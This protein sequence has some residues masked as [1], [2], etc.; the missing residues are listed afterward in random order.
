[1]PVD[2]RAIESEILAGFSNEKNRLKDAY[3]NRRFYEG[4]FD[5][6]PTRIEGA[7]Y[8]RFDFRRTSRIM[9]RIVDTLCGHLYKKPPARKIPGDKRGTDSLASIYRRNQMAAMWLFA[10]RMTCVGDFA[11]WQFAGGTDP[12]APVKIHLRDADQTIVWTDGSDATKAGAVGIIEMANG[13]RVLRLWTPDEVRTYQTDQREVSLP[14]QQSGGTAYRLINRALNPY[15]DTD[16]AGILPFSF[17]HFNFPAT[18]FYSGGI[19]RFL[20]EMNDHLNYRLD[21]IGDAV[22]YLGKPI[23]VASGVS[24]GWTP[25]R[26]V[27][28]GMFIN[29]NADG[30]GLDANGGGDIGTLSYLLSGYDPSID[31]TDINFWIDRSL[32]DANVPPGTIR[33]A[34]AAQSGI[35]LIIKQGPLISF[36]E[37]RRTPFAEYEASAARVA[38][39]VAASHLENN[40]RDGKPFRAAADAIEAEG[41]LLAWPR[42]QILP[43]GPERDQA[44]QWELDNGITSKIQLVMSRNDYSREQALE[45]LRQVALDNAALEEMGIDPGTLPYQPPVPGDEAGAMNESESAEPAPDPS[46]EV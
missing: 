45:H 37:N 23:G 2:I 36:A 12:S 34:E 43:P 17:V 1:M 46:K 27:K 6:Y 30:M 13:K 22:R 16:G 18:T 35:A 20:R 39:Q 10:D 42:L 31:W 3:D 28:P 44:D 21:S 5:E 32:E 29:L 25:P 24:P 41:L 26:E 15:R 40:N 33:F 7:H 19:G 14:G 38:L 9:S 4:C 11:T 8:S